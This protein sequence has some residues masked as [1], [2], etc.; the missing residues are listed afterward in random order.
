MD[1]EGTKHLRA[2]EIKKIAGEEKW[3]RYHVFSIVRNP[4]DRVAS[5]YM[6]PAFKHIN[7]LS[8]KTLNYF[9][10][11]YQPKAHEH[12][13]TCSEYLD[14]KGINFIGKYE[15]RKEDLSKLSL[16]INLDLLS[17]NL[18]PERVTANRKYKWYTY[19]KQSDFD[20]IKKMYKEDI[21]RF[22]YDADEY[23][24]MLQNPKQFCASRQLI[25]FNTY[26]YFNKLTWLFAKSKKSSKRL[27]IK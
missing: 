19:F 9:L 8:G 1:Q 2:S 10:N 25:K 20:R 3:S 6:Q 26:R 15:S 7:F 12:G 13:K 18:A 22:N 16:E 21:K 17:E 11:H 27:L 24:K 4:W 23:Q 14:E 5:L